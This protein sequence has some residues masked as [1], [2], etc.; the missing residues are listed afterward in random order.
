[1]PEIPDRFIKSIVTL[2]GDGQPKGTAFVMRFGQMVGCESYYLIT[3]EHCTN[4][5]V[6]ARFSNG[7][8]IQIEPDRWCKSPTGDDVV[9][10]DITEIVLDARGDIGNIDIGDAVRR[11]EPYFGIGSDLY[12]LGVSVDEKDIGVNNPRARFGNLSGFAEDD[13]SM[14]QGNNAERPCHLGDMR[15]R[16]GFSGSPVIGYLE[17]P[18][19][20][21]HVNYRHRLFGIHSA[22]HRERIEIFS[23]GNFIAAEIPSSMTRIVPAWILEELLQHQSLIAERQLRQGK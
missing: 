9:A 23:A 4:R 17:L 11:R 16:T 13:V 12:M 7:T 6:Q 14:T 2:L 18:A 10:L 20:D 8:S 5:N 19:L 1:M 15:S 22:Q 3:C 21:S